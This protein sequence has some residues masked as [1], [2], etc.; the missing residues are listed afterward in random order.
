MYFHEEEKD[1]IA[2]LDEKDGKPYSPVIMTF[3]EGDSYLCEF[4]TDYES[5]NEYDDDDPR[6][7]EFWEMIYRVQRIIQDGSNLTYQI[8]PDGSKEPIL[9][10]TYKHFPSLVT[11]EDGTIIY[12]D[13]RNHG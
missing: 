6:F 8:L 7:D 11:L 12:K 9:V 1:T 5:M 3:L 13:S 2:K 10:I 4:D